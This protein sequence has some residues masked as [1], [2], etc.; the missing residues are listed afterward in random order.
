MEKVK[1]KVIQKSICWSGLGEIGA[2]LIMPVSVMILARIL[3]PE[4]F[5]ILAICNM[6]IFFADII[7]DAGFGKYIVQ[8]D[9]A[10]EKEQDSAANVA[11]WSHAILSLLI[12]VGIAANRTMIAELLGSEEYAEVITVASFQLIIM[13]LISTQMGILRRQFEFKKLFVVRI[14]TVL[15]PL[16]ITVPLAFWLRSY[17]ALV[18]GNICGYSVSAFILFLLSTWRPK[19]SYSWCVLKKMFS[20]SFWSLCEGLAHWM[21]FWVDTFIITQAYSS[22]YVGLYKNSTAMVISIVGMITASMSPVLLAVL[23]R[24]KSDK[25]M[26][27]TFL[28][29]E[30]LVMYV[31]FPI[32]IMMFFYRDLITIILFGENW[33]EAANIIGAWILMM[34]ISVVIYSF[35]AEVF[36]SQGMPKYLFFYQLIYLLCLIPIC[37]YASRIGFWEFVYTR[38]ACISI[39]FL[40]FIFFSKKI[41]H[42][43]VKP[44]LFNLIYPALLALFVM[45]LCVLIY[46]DSYNLVECILSGIVVFL[47]TLGIMY[48]FLRKDIRISLDKIGK[49]KIVMR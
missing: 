48:L 38:A 35:P 2:K 24:M 29:I 5:G 11:F 49:K 15:V 28:H 46:R 25:D 20:F 1:D 16:V 30:K 42:W 43:N 32:C 10:D 45:L 6:L 3:K 8:A 13:S 27:S 12:W 44:F 41:L 22:Y 7:T 19:L 36:K 23:S 39:Q 4:D 40:L 37:I 14:C 34:M 26:Y 9:F 18:I 31:L 21:I 33:M 17:W 47:L